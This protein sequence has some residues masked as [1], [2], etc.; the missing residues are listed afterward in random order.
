M[1]PT[2]G[3]NRCC[4]QK[5]L[6]AVNQTTTED[7]SL[8]ACAETSKRSTAVIN[9]VSASSSVIVALAGI[10]IGL[11]GLQG[12]RFSISVGSLLPIFGL[13]FRLE[14]F[15]S[16]FVLLIS[17]VS[18]GI[19]IYS[20]GYLRSPGMPLGIVAIFPLFMATLEVI[21]LAGSIPTFL[22]FW[23]LMAIESL[24][25]VLA[26]PERES[27]RSA[28]LLYLVVTQLGFLAIVA[29]SS[30]LVGTSHE[31]TFSAIT[32]HRIH[33]P[34][35]RRD[36][37]FLLALVGFG[38]KAGLVPLH[39]WLPK[40]H[41]E[42][43]APASA[44][45]STAMVALGIYGLILFVLVLCGSAPQWWGVVLVA[46]G[47]ASSVYGVIESSV[48]T[49]LKV[50]LAYST[51]E[52]MGLVV[53]ALGTAIVMGSTGHL[54]LAG[55][56]AT[57]VTYMLVSHTTFKSLGF[58]VTGSVAGATK[59]TN[60]NELGG[61]V[62]KLR[63]SSAA[64][65]VTALSASGL[66]LGAA[67]VGEWILIQA[68]IHLGPTRGILPIVAPLAIG[69]I[70]LTTGI[71]VLAMVKAFGIGFLG[72]NR[73][74]EAI[75]AQERF[76]AIPMAMGLLVVANL[77]I[78]VYPASLSGISA[79]LNQVIVGPGGVAISGRN[80][81]F[82]LAGLGG[83]IYP[84][85]SVAILVVGAILALIA[86]GR[87]NAKKRSLAVDLWACGARGLT[88]RMQYNATS[89]AEPLERIFADVVRPRT[90][91]ET[92]T[93][94]AS[95]L[96]ISRVEYRSLS[97]DSIESTL[98]ARVTAIVFA[99][100]DKMRALHNGSLRRYIAFGA[101]GLLV[102]LAVAR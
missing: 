40:A 96:I 2:A 90:D 97:H 77:A 32:S 25:L 74:G 64:F 71:S 75:L 68:L 102:V 53:M 67:F 9:R 4:T 11:A 22:F 47:A 21:P 30:V 16:I 17:A 85:A 24:A 73:G 15:G 72:K 43:P 50:L 48:A 41:P 61:L 56:A 69:A 19:G 1:P 63:Y 37:I 36:V 27:S 58:M 33:I 3:G 46:V 95:N 51:S 35:G 84:I 62:A 55:V 81:Q 57:A 78:A 93:Y 12:Y 45:M 31:M 87:R 39:A 94:E 14:V 10:A 70:A 100:G 8:Q 101:I 88:P 18:L 59:T 65:G 80:G 49:D 52:N 5:D 6:E 79:K 92:D 83:S 54:R 66:P 23:E 76:G 60:L 28:G 29:A 89:F 44:L 38:S 42:A 20:F 98:Y 91:V 34:Q 82:T 26:H 86:I 13:S 7:W 99:L